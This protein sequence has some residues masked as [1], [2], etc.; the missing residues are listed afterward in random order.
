[1]NSVNNSTF[2]SRNKRTP[3]IIKGDSIF[4]TGRKFSF[5]LDH[6]ANKLQLIKSSS[7][8]KSNSIR[9]KSKDKLTGEL[10]LLL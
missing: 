4:S 1:L 5:H 6:G 8:K 9:K 2:D 7:K 3:K 10:G